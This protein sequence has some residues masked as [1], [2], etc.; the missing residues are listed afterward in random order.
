MSA[1]SIP[2]FVI[3]DFFEDRQ[4]RV[5]ILSQIQFTPSFD[6]RMR[7]IRQSSRS[8]SS[9]HA[10]NHADRVYFEAMRLQ[11]AAMRESSAVE[12]ERIGRPDIAAIIRGHAIP[13]WSDG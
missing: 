9:G 1:A 2:D 13:E 5:R 11:V 6:H 4:K 7:P 3:R 10:I 12:A 8:L